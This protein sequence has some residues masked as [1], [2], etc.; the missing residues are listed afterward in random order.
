MYAV[1]DKKIYNFDKSGIEI[2]YYDIGSN[3][4]KIYSSGYNIMVICGNTAAVL[5]NQ[6]FTKIP[7]STEIS[8]QINR[9]K[10][11][12]DNILKN[13]TMKKKIEK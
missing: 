13:E 3:I 12:R 8:E 9:L 1:K 7:I 10:I 2:S 4:E 5:K 6:N 11:A